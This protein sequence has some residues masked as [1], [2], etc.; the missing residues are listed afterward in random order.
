MGSMLFTKCAW[1]DTRETST[2]VHLK[3]ASLG[4]YMSMVGKNFQTL[5]K[6]ITENHISPVKDDAVGASLSL[7]FPRCIGVGF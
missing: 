6:D 7:P 4:L 1:W 3:I 5:Q 2:Y